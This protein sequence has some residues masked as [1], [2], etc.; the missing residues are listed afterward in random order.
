MELVLPIPCLFPPSG[1]AAYRFQLIQGCSRLI[2]L[3]F[4][5]LICRRCKEKGVFLL[6][7]LL[8]MVVYGTGFLCCGIES[9]ER[10]VGCLLF[11]CNCR[12]L[13][14]YRLVLD[15]W[16]SGSLPFDSC[17]LFLGVRILS[18]SLCLLALKYS[19]SAVG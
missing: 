14:L 4:R 9:L 18:R 5:H 19:P 13:E 2:A 12:W 10:R 1:R 16:F 7:N 11:Y 17:V 3:L 8:I 6:T 15:L